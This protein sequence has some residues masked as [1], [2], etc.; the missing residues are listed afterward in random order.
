ML[1]PELSGKRSE[2]LPEMVSSPGRV[3]VPRIQI[4]RGINSVEEAAEAARSLGVS[5]KPESADPATG[6]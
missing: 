4:S 5:L 1:R 6:D 3:T 2:L